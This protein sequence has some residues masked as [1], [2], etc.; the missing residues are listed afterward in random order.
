MMQRPTVEAS[1]PIRVEASSGE[2]SNKE[3]SN[4]KAG[5]VELD[6]IVRRTVTQ[7]DRCRSASHEYII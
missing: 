5:I 7:T 2:E 1:S 4:K 6:S 3:L